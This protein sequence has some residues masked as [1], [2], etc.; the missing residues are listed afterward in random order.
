MAKYATLSHAMTWYKGNGL[1]HPNCRHSVSIYI[2]GITIPPPERTQREIEAERDA[3]KKSQELNYTNRQIQ[4]WRN[5]QATA[6][7]PQEKIKSTAKLK[8]WRA[9]KKE[10]LTGVKVTPIKAQEPSKEKKLSFKK[11]L[12]KFENTTRSNAK[13]TAGLFDYKGNLL[14]DKRGSKNEVAFNSAEVAQMPGNILTHNHPSASAFS[15]EDVYMLA[16]TGLKEIRAVGTDRE[17]N[18][19][20]KAK[21]EKMV[22]QLEFFE[23]KDAYQRI[24]ADT[25]PKYYDK[26][27]SGELTEK[28][29]W[30]EH[31]HE[32][33]T[34]LSSEM[35]FNYKRKLVK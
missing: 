24:R 2:E 13:E 17:Y 11:E 28:Q 27:V 16:H 12:S 3:Y 5:R 10:L 30:Q 14:F 31:S 19:S 6:I 21:N 18:L 34:K 9:R 1:F 4:S 8:D 35:G 7:T 20:I 25:K 23:I 32:L 33:M 22:R 29:A 26:V 15:P